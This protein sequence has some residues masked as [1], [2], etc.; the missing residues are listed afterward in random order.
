MTFKE[1]S[2]NNLETLGPS[3]PKTISIYICSGLI[4]NSTPLDL[5]KGPDLGDKLY[6]F[7][8]CRAQKREKSLGFPLG[9]SLDS[10]ELHG[11][12]Y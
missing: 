6:V 8:R 7:P 3:L 4:I 2:G 10:S 9:S 5:Q 1:Y 11:S 12:N